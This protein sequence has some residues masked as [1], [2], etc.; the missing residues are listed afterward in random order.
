MDILLRLFAQYE[1]D[2]SRLPKPRADANAIQDVLAIVFTL[3]GAI[4]VLMFVIGGFR[5]ITAQGDP[6]Q[7]S[8]AKETLIYSI[9][10]VVVSISA[11]AIVAFVVGRAT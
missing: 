9:V 1:V 11:V 4:A 6:Q 2:T 10:G 3:I 5:Y 7:I 8:K